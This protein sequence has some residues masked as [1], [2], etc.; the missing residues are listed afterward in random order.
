MAESRGIAEWR[1]QNKK[2]NRMGSFFIYT[3]QGF[4]FFGGFGMFF[5]SRSINP[6][7][8]LFSGIFFSGSLL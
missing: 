3:S 4:Y 6:L 7:F 2:R 5:A 1:Y 8:R